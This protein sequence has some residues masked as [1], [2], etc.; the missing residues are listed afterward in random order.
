[1]NLKIALE[2]HQN[3]FKRNFD[4]DYVMLIDMRESAPQTT[5]KAAHVPTGRPE[6]RRRIE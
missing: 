4:F 5:V 2:G 1:M 6:K 3:S